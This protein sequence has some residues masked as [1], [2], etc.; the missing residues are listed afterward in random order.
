MPSYNTDSFRLSQFEKN[1][2]PL[3]FSSYT[4]KFRSFMSMATRSEA[5][6]LR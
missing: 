3:R 4:L 1:H 2:M 5:A 6:E